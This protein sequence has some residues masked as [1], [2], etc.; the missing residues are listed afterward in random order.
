MRLRRSNPS[1]PGYARRRRGRSFTYVDSDGQPIRDEDD[2]GRLRD[3]VI[4]PAWRDV[5]ISPDPRG[6][7][8]A[9][10][11]DAAGRRQYLYHP[12]WRAK[13]DAAKF[14][15]VLEVA[16]RLPHLRKQATEDLHV[17]GMPRVRVLA[18]T[19]RLLDL[20]LFRVGG[21]EYASGDEPSYGIATLRP[22]HARAVKGCVVF[23]YVAKGGVA[24]VQ[25]VGDPEVCDVLNALRRQRRDAERLFAYRDGGQWKDVH[26]DDINGYLREA[27]GGEMTAKDFRTWH[28]TVLAAVDLAGTGPKKSL[29]GRR[30]AVSAAMRAVAEQLGNTPTVARNSYVDP[31][32]VDRYHEGAVVNLA[33]VP[34]DNSEDAQ[35]AT[36]QA[37]LDL[38]RDA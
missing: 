4:P 38:L 25:T 12:Q 28:G 30:K 2:L 27:S 5:W 6:H 20:G 33:G 32:V 31:R 26:S 24:R 1:S 34:A 36:E 19:A 8:Q 11:V 37:V 15:R 10:G 22:D 13:R 18:L 3:L 21:D 16:E 23:E 7:I 29:T 9:T 14:D 17:R 35:Y